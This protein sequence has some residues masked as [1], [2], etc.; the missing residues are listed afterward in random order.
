M[1]RQ[2]ERNRQTDLVP[3]VAPPEVGH[4]KIYIFNQGLGPSWLINGMTEGFLFKNMTNRFSFAMVGLRL[5]KFL[6]CI[7][8]WSLDF[9]IPMV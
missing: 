9:D 6:I 5:K 7:K 8:Y 2:R 1:S 4:L 3:E